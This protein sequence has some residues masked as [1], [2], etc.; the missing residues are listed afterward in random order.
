MNVLRLVLEVRVPRGTSA[1]QAALVERL[2]SEAAAVRN[3]DYDETLGGHQALGI[4]S[5]VRR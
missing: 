5:H 2:A 3:E 1:K 4:N